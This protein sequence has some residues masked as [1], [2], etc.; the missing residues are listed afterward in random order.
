LCSRSSGGGAVYGGVLSEEGSN[1]GA[2]SW[3]LGGAL[4]EPGVFSDL[5]DV[6]SEALV[7]G[8]HLVEHSLELHGGSLREGEGGPSRATETTVAEESGVA[9]WVLNAISVVGLALNHVEEREETINH[10]VENDTKAVDIATSVRQMA[11]P[12]RLFRTHVSRR[13]K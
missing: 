6:G 4:Q 8:E 3:L 1:H 12:L 2:E 9:H 10:R 13:P 11:P 5:E 7:L